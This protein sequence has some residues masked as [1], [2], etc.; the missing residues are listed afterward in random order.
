MFAY[1]TRQSQ[2]ALCN[3]TVFFPA[4]GA[5]FVVGKSGSGKSTLGQLLLRFYEP[6]EGEIRLDGHPLHTLYVHWHRENI[7]LVEQ[8]SVI[9][10]DII[11]RNIAM[12]KQKSEN[13]TVEEV[14]EAT[15]FALL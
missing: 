14:K 13:V 15:Q 4:G 12:A 11:F 2:L 8:H 9:F 6:L 1:P 7:T 3:A 10:D 5:I